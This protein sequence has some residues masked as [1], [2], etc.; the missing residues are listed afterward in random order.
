MTAPEKGRDA[1]TELTDYYTPEAR[2]LANGW[3]PGEDMTRLIRQREA[4]WAALGRLSPHI[5]DEGAIRDAIERADV[6]A[7]SAAITRQ[8]LAQWC[9]RELQ[10][11][12]ESEVAL[13]DGYLRNALS[14]LIAQD[15]RAVLA[16]L[17][18]TEDPQGDAAA[19]RDEIAG[20]IEEAL[21]VRGPGGSSVAAQPLRRRGGL[22]P[23]HVGPLASRPAH[24][25]GSVRIGG[26]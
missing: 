6:E 26:Y 3:E 22:I 24:M 23:R 17:D 13:A 7:L 11:G 15:P 8:A 18:R 12:F 14:A 5:R 21:R 25:V 9:D 1:M 10:S 4:L 19:V 20:Y 16:S 2:L